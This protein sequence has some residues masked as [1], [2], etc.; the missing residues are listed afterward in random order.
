MKQYVWME[1]TKDEYELPVCVAR[2]AEE[3]AMKCG[4]TRNNVISGACR[5][6]KGI[7]KSRFVKIELDAEEEVRIHG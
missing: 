6:G 1:V 4:T 5:G 2:T 3:L 7:Y